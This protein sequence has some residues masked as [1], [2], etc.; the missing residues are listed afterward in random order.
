MLQSTGALGTTKAVI[1]RKNLT[2]LIAVLRT[3]KKEAI[4]TARSNAGWQLCCLIDGE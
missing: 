1:L 3:K 4:R 2:K